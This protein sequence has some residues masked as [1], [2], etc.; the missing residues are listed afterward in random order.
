MLKHYIIFGVI[1]AFLGLLVG[2]DEQGA[3]F[4]AVI[5]CLAVFGLKFFTT[6]FFQFRE[7]LK[8][9]RK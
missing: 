4:G 3:L 6:Y 5:G 8:R 9:T 2:Q 1:G 7:E